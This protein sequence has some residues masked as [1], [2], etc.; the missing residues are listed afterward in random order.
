MY[1]F[2]EYYF[3]QSLLICQSLLIELEF[4]ILQFKFFRFFLTNILS[5]PIEMSK[6]MLC[7][8]AFTYIHI[9][10]DVFQIIYIFPAYFILMGF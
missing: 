8:Y 5:L 10:V 9:Y 4:Y 1:A 6:L 2:E 3:H 7:L